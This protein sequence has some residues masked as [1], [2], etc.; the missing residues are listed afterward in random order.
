MDTRQALARIGRVAAQ[1]P[2]APDWAQIA[3]VYRTPQWYEEAKFGIFIHWGLYAVPAFGNEWYARNMYRAGTP[4]YEHHVKTYGPPDRFGYK[5]FIPRFQAERFDPEAW[6]RLFA[7]SGARF[8]VPVAEHHDGFAMYGSALNPFNALEMG[9][10]R[11]LTGELLRAVE[12]QGLIPGASSHRAE[13][14][15]FMDGVRRLP[16]GFEGR[17]DRGTAAGHAHEARAQ[18]AEAAH[19]LADLRHQTDGRRL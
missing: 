7:A 10:R 17:E 18:L 19:R 1:G 15:R 11:D 4:E 3:A 12:A 9:P 2:F 8:V 13:H 16:G 5:D 14:F 6:A